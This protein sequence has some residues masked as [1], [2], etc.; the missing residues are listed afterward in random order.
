[1][2]HPQALRARL[3]LDANVLISAAWKEGSKVTRIWRIPNVDLVTS[4][5]V[6]AECTRNLPREEQQKRLGQLLLAVRVLAFSGTP[7]LENP[8]SLPE[9]DQPVLA[10]AVLA[11]ADFL[12]T[13]DR[14]HFGG[15]YG[16]TVCGL[17]VEPPA[18]FPRVLAEG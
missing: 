11:R 13:G 6:V 7:A 18:S 15:W 16:S 14:K 12:V 3:F 8:P 4:D 2:T 17:R 5:H 9:K 1:M 10:A